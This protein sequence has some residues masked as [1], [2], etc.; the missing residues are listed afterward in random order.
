V[1]KVSGNHDIIFPEAGP[2]SNPQR[3]CPHPWLE[4]GPRLVRQSATAANDLCGFRTLRPPDPTVDDLHGVAMVEA[5]VQGSSD[6]RFFLAVCGSSV[7]HD[8]DV[9]PLRYS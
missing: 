1:R 4:T 8:A 7:R 5:K 6:Y 9:A 2:M 3:D